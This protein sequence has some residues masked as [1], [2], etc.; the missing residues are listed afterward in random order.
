MA[1]CAG[2]C[3]V[4]LIMIGISLATEFVKRNRSLFRE[5]SDSLN[6]EQH[7]VYLEVTRMRAT[8]FTRGILLGLLLSSVAVWWLHGKKKGVVHLICVFVGVTLGTSYLFYLLHGKRDYLLRHLDSQRQIDA[9]LGI[10]RS[11]QRY[12]Y[13]GV[14]LGLA[15]YFAIGCSLLME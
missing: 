3:L 2:I 14:L 15:F 5:L 6:P 10:Y 12:T 1:K 13:L 4:A 11:F 8:I 7:R 9:W